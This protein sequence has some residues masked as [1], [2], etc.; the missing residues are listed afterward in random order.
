MEPLPICIITTYKLPTFN[1]IANNSDWMFTSG[2]KLL[3]MLGG[4]A[5]KPYSNQK[6][7]AMCLPL[8]YIHQSLMVISRT[9]TVMVSMKNF[10]ER[11]HACGWMTCAEVAATILSLLS[12][13]NDLSLSLGAPGVGT[14]RGGLRGRPP[15]LE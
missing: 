13:S 10:T 5:N 15:L 11:M 12:R 4:Q 9:G 2:K 14:P 7:L 8:G 6:Y 1:L 3:F